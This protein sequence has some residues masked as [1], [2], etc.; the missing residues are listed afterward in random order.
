MRDRPGFAGKYH[1]NL[2]T[3]LRNFPHN[4]TPFFSLY[5]QTYYP[6]KTG[7]YSLLYTIVSDLAI[8]LCFV[9]LLLLAWKRM[10][11]IGAY[12]AIAIYW[13][14]N[15]LINLPNLSS[16][17]HFLNAVTEQ[18]ILFW[19]DLIDTPLVLFVFACAS[20]GRRRRQ[21]GWSM[22]LFVLLESILVSWQGYHFISSTLIIGA[23][24]LLVLLH[25]VTGL[26][27][28]MKQME[29]APLD[30]SMAFVY[31]ALLFAYG[32]FLIIYIFSHIHTNLPNSSRDSFLLY[33]ISLMLS[34]AITSL[35]LWGYGLRRPG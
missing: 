32:S 15:G 6:L 16:S 21:L 31:A 18:K 13:L 25:C 23:G 11:R 28:Y 35:G 19:Y 33:Y 17:G 34:A 24:L 8:G 27:Q 29:H 1:R 14:V 4:K 5:K 12:Q 2:R 9:P 7:V 22:A 3:K 30:N 26:Q 10:R 20:A